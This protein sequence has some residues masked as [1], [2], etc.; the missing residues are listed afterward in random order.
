MITTTDY[1]LQESSATGCIMLTGYSSIALHGELVASVILSSV[2]ALTP[3]LNEVI[4]N[5]STYIILY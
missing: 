1:S 3:Y 5:K 2:I 4:F